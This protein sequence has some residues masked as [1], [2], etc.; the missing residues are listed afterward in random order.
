MSM[1]PARSL[2]DI[3]IHSIFHLMKTLALRRATVGTSGMR[4][5]S[6]RWGVADSIGLRICFQ[7][8]ADV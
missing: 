4:P 1:R 3:S 8:G 7:R 5:G 2:R 6:D